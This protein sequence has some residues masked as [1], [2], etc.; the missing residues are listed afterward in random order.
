MSHPLAA[1][2]LAVAAKVSAMGDAA[3]RAAEIL[4]DG[5]YQQ[6]LPP[7]PE[8]PDLVMPSGLLATVLRVLA[9]AGL[10]ILA[11]LAITWIARRL[12]R[13]A[14]DVAAED[15]PPPA[16]L[17]ELP[18]ANAEAL[19]AAGRFADAIHALLLDTLAALS[20]AGRLAP[21]LTSREIVARV[22]LAPG[23]REALG[24]LVDAV[25]VTWFGGAVPAEVDYRR[26][27][28]R[29]HAFRASYRS[30]A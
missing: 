22:P 26:C 17:P 10:A 18:V 1:V 12:D 7:P 15:A 14:Q 21:S 13:G 5:S 3:A 9:V 19:A 16:T 11:V 23:A 8:L 2:A 30:A 24:G 27:L 25:E 28:E 20:R 4:G 6:T 29:F